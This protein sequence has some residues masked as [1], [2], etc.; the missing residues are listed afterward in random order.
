[1]YSFTLPYR[2]SL[3][4]TS[5]PISYSIVHLFTVF[6]HH[7]YRQHHH[8]HS[9]LSPRLLPVWLSFDLKRD[10]FSIVV[11]RP[12]LSNQHSSA[13]FRQ[14]DLIAGNQ[15]TACWRTT[16]PRRLLD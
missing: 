15:A 8:H 7:F 6:G 16:R 13:Q 11:R 3:S 4:F 14:G 12:K 10:R 9:P 1:M 5:G 2:Q